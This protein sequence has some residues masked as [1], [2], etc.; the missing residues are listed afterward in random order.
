MVL[1]LLIYCL[2]YFP[3]FCFF[4]LFLFFVCLLLLLFFCFFFVFLG[5]GGGGGGVLCLSLFC[6]A[7][8]C[9]L[10]SFSIILNRK[11]E[12][13]ALLLLSYE[14]VVTVNVPW[15]FLKVPWVGL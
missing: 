14:R 3:L 13:V 12:L 4:L 2:I 9:D 11:R 10:S 7:L 15:L 1:L 8:R 6:Y 5:G